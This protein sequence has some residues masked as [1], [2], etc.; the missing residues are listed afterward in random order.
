MA[1]PAPLRLSRSDTGGATFPVVGEVLADR[2]HHLRTHRGDPSGL[3]ARAIPP[4]GAATRET[5]KDVP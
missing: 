3:P 4:A 5:E 1:A 2:T